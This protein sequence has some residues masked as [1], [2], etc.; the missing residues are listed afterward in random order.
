MVVF[1]QGW[2]WPRLACSNTVNSFAL[3]ILNQAHSTQTAC[4]VA[5]AQ[6]PAAQ[7]I[8]IE[9]FCTSLFVY[10]ATSAVTS[11]CHTANIAAASGSSSDLAKGAFPCSAAVC[12]TLSYSLSW[13]PWLYCGHRLQRIKYVPC[14]PAQNVN[15]VPF[16]AVVPGSCFLES[17]NLVNIALAFGGAIAVLVYCAASFSGKELPKCPSDTWTLTLRLPDRQ[18]CSAL[19]QFTLTCRRTPQPSCHSCFLCCGENSGASC[20]GVYH[21]PVSGQ[22]HSFSTC[23]RGK[24]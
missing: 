20:L 9:Y 19:L 5:S 7:A 10:V 24:A 17:T 2:F 12:G 18:R 3:P 23:A 6:R 21:C 14:R 11:G 22:L 16:H 8:T 1:G 4:C 13:A 15:V